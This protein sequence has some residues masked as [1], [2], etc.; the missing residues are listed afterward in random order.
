DGDTFVVSVVGNS[1]TAIGV[2]DIITDWNDTDTIDFQGI[3]AGSYAEATAADFTAA[4]TLA[5][6]AIA[7][8]TDV[9][10]VQVGADVIVFADSANNNGTADDAVALIGRTLADIDSGSFI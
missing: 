1:S 7:G 2:W 5:N 3:V 6:A 9:V 4:V 8:G 10:A